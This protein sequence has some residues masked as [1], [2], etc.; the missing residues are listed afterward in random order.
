M[1]G[2]SRT[3]MRPPGVK[4]PTPLKRGCFHFFPRRFRRSVVRL[5][6]RVP[7]SF[8]LAGAPTR[9]HHTRREVHSPRCCRGQRRRGVVSAPENLLCPLVPSS[10]KRRLHGMR[11]PGRLRRGG[12][13]VHGHLTRRSLDGAAPER[14][15]N[16][17][18]GLRGNGLCAPQRA[19]RRA[20][21]TTAHALQ[22]PPEIGQCGTG[23]IRSA[24]DAL[25]RKCCLSTA[26]S[27][28]HREST[29]R[30]R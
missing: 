15:S 29:A 25:W 1:P 18:A 14:R 23:L 24:P 4:R 9:R 6:P 11:S 12:G 7:S 21:G 2:L 10:T 20:I 27:R 8:P 19:R 5:G 3:R 26:L 30:A 17:R 28:V 16:P 13:A 22:A